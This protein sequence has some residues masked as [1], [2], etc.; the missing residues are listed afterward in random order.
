EPVR[1]AHVDRREPGR[2]AAGSVRAYR[3]GQVDLQRDGR[4]SLEPKAASIATFQRR[5]PSQRLESHPEGQDRPESDDGTRC[6]PRTSRLRRAV[7]FRASTADEPAQEGPS[8][9]DVGWLEAHRR[10]RA[11]AQGEPY[12]RKNL[13]VLGLR[14]TYGQNLMSRILVATVPVIGHIAPMLPLC[15]ALVECGHEVAWYTGRKHQRR[16]EAAGARFFGYRT[17]SEYD[18]SRLDETFP[19]RGKLTGVQQL[20]FDMKHVFIDAST[21]QCAD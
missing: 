5:S 17:A 2:H 1:R 11:L 8:L 4:R 19:E 14:T 15:R 3:G 6:A 16:V 12:V 9:A 18:D 20:I 10:C 13:A 21:G 7:E